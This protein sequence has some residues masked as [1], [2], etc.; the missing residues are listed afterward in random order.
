MPTGAVR[1]ALVV[2]ACTLAG[3]LARGDVLRL[4]NGSKFEGVLVSE[5]RRAVVFRSENI[6]WTF[7]RAQVAS[8]RRDKKTRRKELRWEAARRKLALRARPVDAASALYFAKTDQALARTAAARASDDPVIIYGTSW[9][10]WCRKAREYLAAR[11]VA[12]VER[13]VE[14]DAE[15]A[16]QVARIRRRLGLRSQAVPVIDVHGTIIVGFDVKRLDRA[17]AAAR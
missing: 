14:H 6:E 5:T 12:F 13:D 16:R 15:A 8:V 9:C 7:L 3:S 10:G 2:A 17:L 4:K 1:V 11:G